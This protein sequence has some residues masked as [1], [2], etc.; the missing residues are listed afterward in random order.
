MSLLSLIVLSNDSKALTY[1]VNT[2]LKYG[3][4]LA[5]MKYLASYTEFLS[6]CVNA[7]ITKDEAALKEVKPY[8]QT[9]IQNAKGEEL[10]DGLPRTSTYFCVDNNEIIGAI[11]YRHDTN[12]YVERVIRH[13]GYETKPTARCKGVA[14]LMLNWMQEN[15]LSTSIIVTC[16][17]NN[18]ASKKVIERCNGKYINQIYSSEK[19]LKF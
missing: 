6:E 12:E 7:G 4:D 16:E 14:Q 17:I 15:I 13:V 9:L 1:K 3:N 18:V 10:S 8:L 5:D 2:E 11:R 19:M